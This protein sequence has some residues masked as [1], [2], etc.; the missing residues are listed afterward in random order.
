MSSHTEPLELAGDLYR[1]P[2]DAGDLA[3]LTAP[4]YADLV[5]EHGADNVLVLKRFP[6]GT[7]ALETAFVGGIDG[8]Q[9]PAITGLSAHSRRV[10]TELPDPPQLL[11]S[12]ERN[13]L[14]ST[15][16][17]E[18]DWS[19]PYLE[20]A[21]ASESF[22]F[23][24]T[25]FV[26][27]ATWS[28]RAIETDDPVL[29]ELATAVDAFHDWLGD[30]DRLDPARGLGVACHALSDDA[31][32]R[33]VQSAF[34]AVL[35]LELEEFT[36][37]DRAYLARLTVGVPL[38]CVAETDSAIQRTWNEPG[39]IDDYVPGLAL[40][41][42]LDGSD[43]TEA[44]PSAGAG[45]SPA[46]GTS[47]TA[48]ATFLATGARP[49]SDRRSTDAVRVVEAESFGDELAAVAETIERLH[50]DE[51]VPY[52]EMA[53]ALR[54]ANAPIAE[55]LHGLRAAGIPVRSATV[56]GLE[57][58]PTARELY[59]LVSW[60]TR[61]TVPQPQ[62]TNDDLP[63]WD[64][65]RARAVLSARTDSGVDDLDS[66]LE[67]V[68]E[69]GTMGS[70]GDAMDRWIVETGL[71]HRVASGTDS[72]EGRSQFEHVRT[73]RDLARSVDA[74]PLLDADWPTL[75]RGVEAE[76][77]RAT[78]DKVTSDLELPDGGVLVDAVRVLKNERR[79][80]VFL[81]GV[82]DSEYPATPRF[83]PLFPTPHLA[84]LDGYPAFT[85]P[86]ATDVTDTFRPADAPTRPLHA[87]YAELSR[88]L[89]AVGARCATDRLYL[90]LHRE[91]ATGT[92]NRRQPSRFLAAL[93]DAFGAFDR[94]DA[95]G[96]YSHGEAVRFALTRL[97]DALDQVR[98]AGL[99]ADPIDVD[100]VEAEFEA[101]QR[102]LDADPPDELAA[103]LETRLAFAAGEVCRD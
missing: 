9:R 58:D 71:K 79:H 3:S 100:A 101:V 50:R 15:F 57:H 84:E 66:V 5:H 103:A 22:R 11:G 38:V 69:A 95:D 94:V 44:G 80:A 4:L 28:G 20:R 14:L 64:D 98:L 75:C 61:N 76:L 70:L 45:E 68:R 2:F 87:Y 54:D 85:T 82:V 32:R 23:D 51:G 1:V 74:S 67:A 49:S 16:I 92:G 91:D 18:Y 77:Q 65:A 53:V 31:V 99:V 60:C 12:A 13:L 35:A 86:T 34:D 93:E 30:A 90:S 52:E 7:E 48:V 73:V 81:V 55:T 10:L 29:A 83:N 63:G 41:D 17:R 96:I 21:A 42:T 25:K 78:S 46:A 39:P 40:V 33:R 36:A 72:L 62:A 88:R 26:T 47:P 97:D 27:E 37:I 59:A 19:H 56:A 6:T 43:D 102:I 89:L 24:V 8:V